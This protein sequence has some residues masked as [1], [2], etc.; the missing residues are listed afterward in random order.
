M[1]YMFKYDSTHGRFQGTL[2]HKENQLI[3]DGQTIAVYT[4][5]E[6]FFLR[7]LSL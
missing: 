5:Y 4:E 2:S 3:V 1:D 7:S 6:C